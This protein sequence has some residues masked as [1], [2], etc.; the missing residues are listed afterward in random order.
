MLRVAS[1]DTVRDS[2]V[3]HVLWPGAGEVSPRPARCAAR[4]AAPAC[5]TALCASGRC[6]S[7]RYMR[8]DNDPAAENGGSQPQGGNDEQEPAAGQ[9]GVIV[10]AT[11]L[12]G[13][14]DAT[15]HSPTI[16]ADLRVTSDPGVQIAVRQVR[17]AR[18]S[19]RTPVL[20][21]G[22]GVRSGHLRPARAGW[23]PGRR[24]RGRRPSCAQR[25]GFGRRDAIA[26]GRAGR[27]HGRS[28]TDQAG[29]RGSRRDAGST[30]QEPATAVVV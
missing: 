23:L 29:Y 10:A 16:R 8:R 4:T 27:V 20:L 19:P 18:P 14:A 7:H 5:S 24:P 2:R 28:E 3:L 6:T 11:L 9:R 30:Q 22:A 21:R 26:G 15:E 25:G 13:L 12:P 17:P 1:S